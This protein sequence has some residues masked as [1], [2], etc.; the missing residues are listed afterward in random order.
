MVKQALAGVKVAD[1]TWV[2]VGPMTIKR[3]ADHGA[4]VIHVESSTKPEL[5][6]TTPPFK[7]RVSGLNR[8]AFNACFNNNKYGLALD[9]NHP[10]A[11]EVLERLIKWADVVAESFSPGA[12]KKW[13]LAYE[14]LI[15]TKPDLIMYS[16]CQQGQTG[17]RAKI[18]AYGT[19]LVSLSGFTHLTGWPDRDP[20][21]P[22]GPYTDTIVP[23]IGAAAI[24][25]ALIKR[26]RTGKG[27]HIDISQ[28]EVGLN[29]ISPP[30]LDYVVNLRVW[31]RQGNRCPYGVPHGVYRCRGEDRWCAITIFSD[32]EWEKLCEVMGRPGLATDPRFDTSLQRKKNEDELDRIVSEWTAEL[33]AEEVMHLLQGVGVAAGVAQTGRDL[34]ENDAQLAHRQFFWEL[35]HAEI[36]KHSYEA[37]PF[38][39]SK[40][41]AELNKPGPCLGEDTEYVCTKMLGIPDQL[42]MELLLEGVF[43]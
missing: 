13:G 31:S 5:L 1:F 8:S 36:G 10:R 21:G 18:A 16:T 35:N 25:A 22:Y 4:E 17:P 42:F 32:D 27:E 28:L 11:K 43:E 15:K 33:T 7:N 20:T 23:S 37:P 19:Q 30:L 38:K 26:S 34:L 12:M 41:P 2:G 6:R 24:A 40:T 9:M 39:L 14:D 3:L 29:F